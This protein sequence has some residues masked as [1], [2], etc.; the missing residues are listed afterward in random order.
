MQYDFCSV[1]GRFDRPDSHR[2]PPVWRVWI[3]ER[4]NTDDTGDGV[5][6]FA[7]SPAAA[8]KRAVAEKNDEGQY[9]NEATLVLVRRENDFSQE[10]WFTVHGEVTVDWSSRDAPPPP[11]YKR[12]SPEAEDA[13]AT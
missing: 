1:C 2:C 3:H 7:P 6:V 5:K 8:A 10:W 9:I 4:H 13:D 11:D 12:P